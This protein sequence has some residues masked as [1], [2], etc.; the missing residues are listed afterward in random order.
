MTWLPAALAFALV[1]LVVNAVA[2]LLVR[3]PRA[4]PG[5]E[6]R[7]LDHLRELQARVLAVV[8]ATAVLF[9]AFF[10]FGVREVASLAGFPVLVPWP[11]VDA[12]V[13]ALA[14]RALADR[15]TP[16]GVELVVTS[17]L[18]GVVALLAVALGLTALAVVPAVAWQAAAFLGPALFESE[19]RAVLVAVPLAVGLFLAGA[20]FGWLLVLPNV[21][22]TLYGYA[23]ALEARLLLSVHALVTF[24]AVMLV[25][26]GV[27]FELPLVMAALSRLGL[28]SPRAWLSH[29]RHAIVAI[30]VV[31]A[32]V[33]PDPT[34][35]SQM[36]VAVP[37]LGLYFL[38]AGVASLAR[39]RAA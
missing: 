31:A 27:A 6:L 32:V 19:R 17:P 12:S 3:V 10:A 28:V 24:A 21:F 4:A 36:F 26:F 35:V 9:F 2:I 30:V 23:S 13:A 14:F 20:A 16:A 33:T 29:W 25:V 22:A 38:G 8:V 34:V 11:S 7:L 15:F 5:Q 1:A 37:L 18:D 39:P